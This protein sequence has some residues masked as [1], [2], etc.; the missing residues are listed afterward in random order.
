MKYFTI[1]L[2]EYLGDVFDEKCF[3]DFSGV[4]SLTTFA[5]LVPVTLNAGGY[6]M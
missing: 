3:A 4:S 1:H 5:Y 2:M 6:S